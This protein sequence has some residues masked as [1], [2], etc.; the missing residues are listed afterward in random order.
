MKTIERKYT[1]KCHESGEIKLTRLCDSGFGSRFFSYRKKYLMSSLAVYARPSCRPS[2][3]LSVNREN[4]FG[5]RLLYI[6]QSDSFQ[7][8]PKYR[9]LGNAFQKGA[10]FR[11][12]NCKLQIYA[13]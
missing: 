11:N 5:Q 13:T 8:R 1:F 7:I 10:I 12:S 9:G 6:Y 3:C 4:N 2:V